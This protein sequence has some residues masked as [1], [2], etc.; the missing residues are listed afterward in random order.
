[1]CSLVHCCHCF[2]GTCWLHLQVW[3]LSLLPRRW[4]QQDSLKCEEWSVTH[5]VPEYGNLHSHCSENHRFWI[6]KVVWFDSLCDVL[7]ALYS[8]VV[9]WNEC[10][11]SNTFLVSCFILKSDISHV[12]SSLTLCYINSCFLPDI[13]VFVQSFDFVFIQRLLQL[14]QEVN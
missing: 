4:R 7:W 8:C 12:H 6:L 11:F 2:G 1:M 14:C 9:L 13:T 3:K 10:F 5:H